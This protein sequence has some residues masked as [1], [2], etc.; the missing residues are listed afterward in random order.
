LGS[1]ALLALAACSPKGPVPALP[2]RAEVHLAAPACPQQQPEEADAL[3]AAAEACAAPGAPADALLT[4]ARW[5]RALADAAA[6]KAELGTAEPRELLD[7]QAA[8]SRACA[9]AARRALALRHPE[10][11]AALDAARPGALSL[12][13]APAAELLYLEAACAAAWARAQGFTHVALRR[14]ELQAM[15]ERAAALD[16]G[17]DD[18]GPDR[19]LGRLL[20]SLPASAGGSLREARLRFEAAVARA[21][22]SVRNRVLFARGVAVKVQDRALFESLLQ[23][24]LAQPTAPGPEALAAAEARSLLSREADL[25]GGN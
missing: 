6:A 13:P 11:A 18:A 15:L 19:E 12:V 17:L 1:A 5:Y 22:R 4:A 23:A 8:A 21:P 24:A 10:A 2:A 7:M 25:F 20:S 3:E 16:P 14:A 9:A